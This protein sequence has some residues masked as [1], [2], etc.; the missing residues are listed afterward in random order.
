MSRRG[1]LLSAGFWALLGGAVLIASWRM[2]RLSDRGINPLSAPGLTPGV[3]G[4][5]M[6]VL[7]LLL[8]W[9]ALRGAEAQVTAADDTATEAARTT[10]RT[11]LAAGLCVLFALSLGRGLPFAAE[12]AT[13][14]FGFT[15]VF[16]WPTWRTERRIARGLAQTL[17]IAVAAALAISWLFESV[18]LVRLP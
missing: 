10:S 7:A 9:R 1:E 12:A 8:G 17:A 11:L 13:F 4:A 3:V 18:F 14:V 5:L 2:D 15:C 16:S 6:L